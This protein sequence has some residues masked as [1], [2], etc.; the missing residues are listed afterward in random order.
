MEMIK[1][2]RGNNSFKNIQVKVKLPN[3]E[4]V[5]T[6]DDT[7]GCEIRG[8]RYSKIIPEIKDS[9]LFITEKINYLLM[10]IYIL[11]ILHG[12]E[13]A[14]VTIYIPRESSLDAVYLRNITGNTDIKEIKCKKLEFN[15]TSGNIL[16]AAC[17]AEN[18]NARQTSGRLN[19][20]GCRIGN[21]EIRNNS[22][23]L[24]IKNTN[25]QGL[26]ISTTSGNTV[27]TGVVIG[28]TDIKSTS[29]NI[30][31]D[32]AAKKQNYGI[33]IDI[34]SGNAYIDGQKQ[35]RL[36]DKQFNQS[37]NSRNELRLRTLSGN[38]IIDFD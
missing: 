14:G 31:L 16:A 10:A 29:G 33:Y 37:E 38:V 6:E 26:K 7:Y 21:G 28:K 32:I 23:N 8:K 36:K 34:H 11:D 1:M 30:A 3:V 13:K 12:A 25:L 4:T 17:S 20:D 27:F 18:F 9:T 15:A 22:G 2:N 19:M 24:N 35:K 5:I